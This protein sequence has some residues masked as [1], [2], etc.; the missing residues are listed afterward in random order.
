[1]V[2]CCCAGRCV[3]SRRF[4]A[5]TAARAAAR[6]SRWRVLLPAGGPVQGHACRGACAIGRAAAVHA[7][8]QLQHPGHGEAHA[9]SLP[10]AL[11]P[12]QHP[13]L[14]VFLRAL[15]SSS[16]HD[17]TPVVL[18][19]AHAMLLC[20]C[21]MLAAFPAPPQEPE[22]AY[23]RIAALCRTLFNVSSR[24]CELAAG[25]ACWAAQHSSQAPPPCRASL[26]K[27][28]LATGSEPQQRPGAP[29]ALRAHGAR[30][31]NMLVVLLCALCVRVCAAVCR[32]P[33]RW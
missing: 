19:W 24:C 15:Y 28:Q 4:S 22:E 6:G 25:T 2:R 9:A 33:L 23:D 12:R 30:A 31:S 32:C 1:V 8:L 16:L 13:G 14:L 18:C 5:A 10:H 17:N 27:R 21:C 20:Y 7:A 11:T 29:G 3:G 26:L